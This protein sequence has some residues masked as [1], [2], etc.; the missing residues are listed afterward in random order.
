[1][2][3]VHDS[4]S[5]SETESLLR[6]Q[7]LKTDVRLERIVGEMR[8]GFAE[9]RGEFRSELN[10]TK[11]ELRAEMHKMET[12]LIVWMIGT[13]FVGLG[14]LFALLRLLP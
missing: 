5:R 2:A 13:M 6:E 4:L 7:E 12:R 10:A 11:G 14:T 9:L 1:M 8:T 3:E